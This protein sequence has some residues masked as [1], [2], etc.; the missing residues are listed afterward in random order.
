MKVDQDQTANLKRAQSRSGN[1][2]TNLTGLTVDINSL[3]FR[4]AAGRRKND[5]VLTDGSVGCEDRLGFQFAERNDSPRAC[6]VPG[7][8][9]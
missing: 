6:L 4:L 5:V 3:G 7:E 2:E 8:F 9:F 1:I